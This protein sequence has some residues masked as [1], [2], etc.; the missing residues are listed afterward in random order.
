MSKS[1]TQEEQV[2]LH[3][4]AMWVSV[5]QGSFD[6]IFDFGLKTEQLVLME[7]DSL[8]ILPASRL[9]LHCRSPQ[10]QTLT[11]ERTG[12]SLT[13]DPPQFASP[14]NLPF[15]SLGSA[16]P[17]QQLQ[18]HCKTLESASV[19]THSPLFMNQLYA[20]ITAES[21]LA[22][23]VRGRTRTTLS[24]WEA[25]PAF[26]AVE[27]EVVQALIKLIGWKQGE[28]LSVPGGSS[29]NFMGL[30]L[31]RHQSYPQIKLRGMPAKKLLV[32]CSEA[33]HYSCSKAMAV[34]GLGTS[35]LVTL[36]NDADGRIHPEALRE[37]LSNIPRRARPLAV[38]ATSGTTVR[39]AFDSIPSLIPLVREHKL[40]LHVDAAW[41]GPVLY[42]AR[43]RSL[44][45]G[46]EQADS[47][48]FDA[49]KLLGAGI[50]SSFFLTRHTPLLL[51]ANDVGDTRYL[52]HGQTYLDRGRLSWQCGRGA[53]AL[54]F[55]AI[56]K[57]VG[58]EGL[59]A[60]V[61]RM[62]QLCVDAA[63]LLKH[64]PRFVL[65]HQPAYLNACFRIR[66]AQSPE[67]IANL[68]DV[69]QRLLQENHAMINYSNDQK[70][71]FI[72]MIFAHPRLTL[73]DVKRI[74]ATILELADQPLND[75]DSALPR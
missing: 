60:F 1:W 5:E 37:A 64:H 57:S 41:G 7:G 54:N 3:P 61:D 34:L 56:W 50:P 29:A 14:S 66:Q 31:A 8:V 51:E 19:S 68:V 27:V 43:L 65:M 52:F 20:G 18:A 49:H 24:T 25:S 36:A 13:G 67:L 2:L 55:W 35:Q 53:E 11:L 44:M 70:G 59:G 71:P 40:W 10:A 69:R 16:T 62:H 58:T 30:H 22:D 26:S 23:Q 74:L 15:L 6:A 42:S 9:T 17:I 75:P 38:V 48:A 46:I 39:G 73:N 72:R 47:V 4:D 12:Q 21:L 32:Y 33:A 45:E 28:G 63:Q